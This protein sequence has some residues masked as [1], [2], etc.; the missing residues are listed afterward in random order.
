VALCQKKRHKLWLWK[1][2]DA[3][4]GRLLDWECDRRDK[5]TLMK[6]IGRLAQWDVT[7][8]HTD[9]WGTYAAVLPQDKLVQSKT[10]TGRIERNHCRQR[11]W[12]GRFR[13]KSIIMSKSLK[14]WISRWRSLLP[15]G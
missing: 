10:G 7:I 1:A 6:M 4:T 14:W 13:R 8:Y 12:F 3:I 5:A 11:H 15:S 9:K 2:L